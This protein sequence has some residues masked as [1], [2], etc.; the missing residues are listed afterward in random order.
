[1]VLK[2]AGGGGGTAGAVNYLGT[3]NASTN[4]P[5]LVSG[6]GTKGGYY[7]VSVAG[8]T[9]LDGISLWSIGDWAVFNGSVW[10]K[11]DGSA[12]EAF[13]GITVTSL[14]GYM[15]ANNTSP[16][17]ASTTI[18]VA[19]VT[20]AVPNTTYVLAGTNLTGGGAL[21]GNVTINNPYNGTVTSVGSGTGLTGGPI[22]GSGT[23]SIA[24]TTV[25]AGA[26]GN[27]TTV[28]TFAVNAQGQ[29]TAAANV[30]ISGTSPGGV[31][32]GD[33]T[34]TYPNP[35]LNTSGV[36]AGIY[37]NASTVSQITLDAK[38][39]ATSAANVTIS[40]PSGQVTG[41]GT[42]ATQNAN[43]VAI[44]GG[45]INSTTLNSDTF[46]NANITSVASTFPNN[47]LSNSAVTL[48]NTSVSLGSTATTIG[49]LTLSNVTITS[50]T[51]PNSAVTGLGTMAYQNANSVAITG[52]NTSVTYDNAVYQIA[53]SNISANVSSG[54]FS[55]GTL[56]YSDTGIVASFANTANSY[57]QMVMQNLSNGTAASTDI[58][59]VNDTSA[60]Y[61]DLGITS[62]NFTGTGKFY[63]ANAAYLYSGAT[64]LYL[65]TI[66]NNSI[67]FVTNN[68]ATD[69][70]TINANGSVNVASNLTASA[71][72][73]SNGLMFNSSNVSAN[74]TVS[75]GY[76]AVSVGPMTL[77]NNVT[78]TVAS[79]Q[80]W[81]VL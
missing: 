64:D 2:V 16:V 68:T 80:R 67:H 5:T 37:G 26:Y 29:L 15:Y 1:M 75:T 78:V 18:P 36:T 69:A 53:T 33:L 54:A 79:G 31:A 62:S 10:Q 11:I 77:A 3:W 44:T 42:M 13:N 47:Y 74:T 20:G 81:V 72:T 7:V 66:N 46:T 17:T 63:S 12:N 51:I 32:G 43:A 14:T 56:G 58:S 45:T 21:T 59:L 9:T 71:L 8:T 60:A 30:T 25:T 41:L 65:G 61:I 22:T 73:V 50:G 40:I 34:G 52:G 57:V 38:G 27:A 23:L 55:Y 4:T 48:G 70:V 24:N 35:T 49:N 76:N 39:R 6:V 19:S 28:A